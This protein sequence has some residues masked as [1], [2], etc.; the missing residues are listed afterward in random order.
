MLAH[1]KSPRLLKETIAGDEAVR[2]RDGDEYEATW[3]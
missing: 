2:G 3:H 1:R